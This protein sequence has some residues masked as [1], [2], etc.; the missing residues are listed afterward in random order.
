[1]SQVMSKH[2]QGLQRPDTVLLRQHT[3]YKWESCS[4]GLTHATNPPERAGEEPLRQYSAGRVEHDGE[5]WAEE[6]AN[7]SNSDPILD[8]GRYGPDCCLKATYTVITKKGRR[9]KRKTYAMA[10]MM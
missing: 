5:H 9:M 8:Q 7:R 3:S 2:L 10:R 6:D 1:M 4:S